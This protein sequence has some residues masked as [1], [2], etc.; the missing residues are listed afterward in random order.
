[1]TK[2]VRVAS[3]VKG[4][5]RGWMAAGNEMRVVACAEALVEKT[6]LRRRFA[7]AIIGYMTLGLAPAL[8]FDGT[9]SNPSQKI[10]RTSPTRSKLCASASM[11]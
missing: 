6:P 11:T 5:R 9:T 10:P 4:L 8:A 1:M 3:A 7:F 2:V